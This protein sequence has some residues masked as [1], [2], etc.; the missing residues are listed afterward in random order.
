MIARERLTT[1]SCS[2]SLFRLS[3]NS[4]KLVLGRRRHFH[5]AIPAKSLQRPIGQIKFELARQ[6][7]K[8]SASCIRWR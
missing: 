2:H 8:R 6:L 4:Q 3:L 7:H 1:G 5:N